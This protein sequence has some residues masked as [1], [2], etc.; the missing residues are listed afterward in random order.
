RFGRLDEDVAQIRSDAER[1]AEREAERIREV[2][3]ADA[4]KI[5]LLTRREID[6]AV[7]SARAELR[8]FVAEH[9]VGLAE[10]IIRREIRPEDDR[11][12]IGDYAE[13]LKEAG[14]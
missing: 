3:A 14:K 10:S 8:A 6:G 5:A 2:A 9:S 7:Q 12:I 1:E 13:Q 4:E 11:R